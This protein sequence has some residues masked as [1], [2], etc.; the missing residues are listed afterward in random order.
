MKKKITVSKWDVAEIL[1]NES[2][3]AGYLAAAF[4]D[5][6]PAI[7]RKAMANV[8]RA[9]NM[10]AI[11]R[12]MGISARGLYKM[13]AEGGNPEFSSVQKFLGAIG[14]RMSIV[15]AATGSGELKRMVA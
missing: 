2:D 13:L 12:N 4:E 10:S 8:A 15:P 5:G 1:H 9:Q 14:V 11:A 6:D 7:I 3:Y